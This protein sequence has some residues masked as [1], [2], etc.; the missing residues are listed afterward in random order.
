MANPKSLGKL[1]EDMVSGFYT[2]DGKD[3]AIVIVA[4]DHATSKAATDKGNVTVGHY[5]E[6]LS[7]SDGKVYTF[8]GMCYRH[9]RKK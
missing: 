2:I 4:V 6:D 3:V 5:R 7:G 9:D 1:P 8:S